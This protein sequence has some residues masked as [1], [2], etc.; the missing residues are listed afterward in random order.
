VII[1]NFTEMI[2]G[3]VK[4]ISEKMSRSEIDSASSVMGFG[5]DS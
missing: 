1:W 2:G 3:N 4:Q 5:D